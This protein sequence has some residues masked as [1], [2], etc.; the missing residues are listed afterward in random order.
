MADTF[1]TLKLSI[2]DKV[3]HIELDLPNRE[4]NLL[5]SALATDLKQV[6]DSVIADDNILGAIISSAKSDF[7]AGADL[8]TLLAN[9][10]LELHAHEADG[11]FSEINALYRRLETSGKPFVAAINGTALGVGLELALACHYRILADDASIKIGFDEVTFG[12]LPATGGTQRLPR[13]IGIQKALPLLLDGKFIEPSQALALAVVDELASQNELAAKAKEWIHNNSA[14]AQPWDVKGFRVPYDAGAMATH[15]NTSFSA[16]LIK[17]RKQTQDNY[18][19]PI[20]ILSAVYE[21]TLLPFDLALEIEAKYFAQLYSDSVSHNL[22]RLQLAH[23]KQTTQLTC[24]PSANSANKNAK[25]TLFAIEALNANLKDQP[26]DTLDTF[27]SRLFFSYIDEAMVMLAE[28]VAPALIENAAMQASFAIAPLAASDEIIFNLQQQGG[29]Q[30]AQSNLLATLLSD[31]AQSVLTLM[32]DNDRLVNNT[33]AGFYDYQTGDLS[34]KGTK[35]SP[36]YSKRLWPNLG[37]HFSVASSQPEFSV[38][39]DRLLYRQAL[40]SVSCVEAGIIRAID[41]DLQA[42]YGL[43]FSS[44]TGGPLSLIET[45]GIRVFVERCQQLT[46]YGER[47]EPSL[48]LLA[49]AENK[50]SFY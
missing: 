15:A 4:V 26:N 17:V 22:I 49:R 8:E 10:N 19:A 24:N 14:P 28:G 3:A 18:P 29:D 1:T 39:R 45:I 13:L 48:W 21:G 16:N 6:I 35:D 36:T 20:A 27:T 23:Q 41:A 32:Q 5:T 30:T 40:E 44:W 38:V 9:Q 31:K 25:T 42:V 47:F 50:Q 12:L 33:S 46:Q 43:G 2:L 11:H 7:M 34:Y 37:K